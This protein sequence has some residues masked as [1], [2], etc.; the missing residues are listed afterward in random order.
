MMTAL[1]FA[2]GLAR[3]AGIVAPAC[4]IAGLLRRTYLYV[5]G[6]LGI[7]LETVLALGVL[8][9]VG[10]LLGLVGLM[11]PAAL[12]PVLVLLAVVVWRLPGRRTAASEL[13]HPEAR[14]PRLGR[15]T[16]LSAA[17]AVVVVSAQW[18]VQTAN[19]LGAGMANFDT[20]WYHMPFAAHM[21]QTSAVTGIKFTQADP[22]VAYYPA[23]SELFHA[24]GIEAM[25]NDFL[26]PLLNLMWLAVALLAAWCV[27]R[28]WRVERLTLIAGCLVLS[29][30]V[31]SGTQPGEAFNDIVGLATLLAAAAFV[32][33]AAED[34][35]LLAVAGLALGLAVGTKF[36]FVVPAFVRV[37]GIVVWMGEGSRWRRLGVL[38]VPLL[39]TAGWWYL[40]NLIAVGNPEGLRLHLGPLT[41]PGPM[42]PLESASEQTVFSQISHLSLWGS[43]FAPGLDH[44]L[45]PV[46]PI[47]LALYVL[48]VV[49]GL[50][51]RGNTSV[52]VLAL[53][54]AITG[55]A[56]LFLPTGAAAIEQG[57]ALFQVNLRYVTPALV[58]GIVLV[59]IVLATH[60]PR[61]LRLVGPALVLVLIVAQ[62]EHELWPTQPARHLAFLIAAGAL[63][64]LIHLYGQAIRR[65]P[66]ETL[67]MAAAG[68]LVLMLAGAFLVQRHYFARR[69]LTGDESE[70]ALGAIY[71][72]AQHT[73][74]ARIALYGTVQQYPLYG[75][76]DTNEVD[77]LGTRTSGGGFRPITSCKAWRA[78]INQGHYRYLVLTP[79]PTAPIPLS[80]TQADPS[81][82]PILAPATNA[83]VYEITG[84]LDPA[85]CS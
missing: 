1:Q 39:L 77:Y 24:L 11:R 3:L 80:W 14:S 70:P 38:A 57:S 76:R 34:R 23:N 65:Q 74:H 27:G 31:L 56:Y 26:S 85:S 8:L 44:A 59:P 2:L 52:R 83:A 43:R 49:V 81:A 45:G 37:A 28:P 61:L 15:L 7:L 63:A 22:Y 51:A 21:A 25:H 20:L 19:A 75:A 82:H 58:L 12:I 30:P 68:L 41:L 35:R 72:W 60:V 79:G 5:S 16:T 67:A 13:E 54:S 36:T 48:S 47:V 18:C 9:V 46:W 32:V 71:G 53:T 64:T 6:A 66:R 4:V 84:P 78:T 62:L 29:L 10:E 33:N 40:R 42:S 69:Y 17:A 55:V 73:A 50:M